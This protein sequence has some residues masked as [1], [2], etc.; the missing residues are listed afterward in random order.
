MFELQ[1]NQFQKRMASFFISCLRSSC[2]MGGKEKDGQLLHITIFELHYG[3]LKKIM[4]SFLISCLCLSCIMV[5]KRRM[6][7][8]FNSCQCLSCI[9]VGLK[10]AWLASLFHVYVRAVLC[11]VK[12]KEGQLLYFMSMF[13][14]YYGRMKKNGQ[15]LHFKVYV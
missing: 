15:L 12:E 8:F 6:A 1:N 13:E 5:G 7:S 10:K 2:I 4:V 11:Q 14:L 3:R 9:V